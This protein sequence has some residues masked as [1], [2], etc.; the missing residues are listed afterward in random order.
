MSKK[1]KAFSIGVNN[2]NPSNVFFKAMGTMFGINIIPAES[3]NND[4]N[5]KILNQLENKE[6][7]KLQLLYG[8]KCG[9]ASTE[10]KSQNSDAFRNIP[11]F[12]EIAP[13][14]LAYAKKHKDFAIEML[15]NEAA[16]KKVLFKAGTIAEDVFDY[17][18]DD[19]QET[20]K[21]I[22][23]IKFRRLRTNFTLENKTTNRR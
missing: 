15:K 9:Y 19:I 14:A 20:G 8:K 6:Y 5:K 16:N 21:F 13:L 17:D 4:T 10:M 23:L 7:T 2:K 22:V 18:L 3:F 1:T 11:Y 12:D